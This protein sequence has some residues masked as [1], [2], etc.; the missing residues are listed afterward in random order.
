MS[1]TY[2]L[3]CTDCEKGLW[4]GQGRYS[5]ADLR[6]YSSEKHLTDMQAFLTEHA[7]HPLIFGGMQRLMAHGIDWVD[8]DEEEDERKS[9][10]ERYHDALTAQLRE[11][12]AASMVPDPEAIP[13][14]TRLTDIYPDGLTYIF[15]PKD[16]KE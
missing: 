12:V 16:V 8:M 5:G 2:H 3:V 11:Q 7:L 1:E 14:G 13:K 4:V 10:R 15:G 9:S 6:V